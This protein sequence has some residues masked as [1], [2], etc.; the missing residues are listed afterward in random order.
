MNKKRFIPFW[1]TPQSWIL[2]GIEKKCAEI[3]YYSDDEV[4]AKID[5]AQLR[6]LTTKEFKKTKNQILYDNSRINL[7]EYELTNIDLDLESADITKEVHKILLRN[8]KLTHGLIT[9]REHDTEVIEDMQDGVNKRLAALDFALKY[10]EIS[11]LEY[12]KEKHTIEGEPWCNFD[13]EVDK[14]TGEIIISFD[15]NELFCKYLRDSGYPGITNDDVIDSYIRDW[16]RKLSSDEPDLEDN[17]G[18]VVDGGTIQTTDG[19]LK[20]HR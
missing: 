1:M 15:Y 4:Q 2:G 11:E 19:L 6:S 14:N 5:K 16:G 7:Y 13:A 9:E 12:Q 17:M 10:K 8:L 18:E 3:D 20:I